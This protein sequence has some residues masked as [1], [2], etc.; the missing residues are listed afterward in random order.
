MSTRLSL[1]SVDELL[2][3][4]AR[5][6]I[7]KGHEYQSAPWCHDCGHFQ[8]WAGKGDAPASFNPCIK[9]H[10]MQFRVPSDYGDEWGFY[11]RDCRDRL[12]DEPEEEA[13]SETPRGSAAAPLPET[14]IGGS[15]ER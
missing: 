1:Y 5:R 7:T 4:L 12:A 13:Q 11:R 8:T 3:E 2:R 15:N 6:R 10:V 14:I 9:R